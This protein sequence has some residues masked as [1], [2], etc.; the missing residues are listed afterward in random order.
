MSV[1]Y[2]GLSS[3]EA[4]YFDGK[5]LKQEVLSRNMRGP[6]F[7]SKVLDLQSGGDVK[8]AARQRAYTEAFQ[9]SLRPYADRAR[10]QGLG[11]GTVLCMGSLRTSK[12]DW[13]GPWTV[14]LHK[15]PLPLPSL[16]VRNVRVG[17]DYE[18]RFS[19]TTVGAGGFS[20]EAQ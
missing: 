3:A 20:T 12:T 6:D 15:Q 9:K 18:V 5:L 2:P 17:S 10:F 19:F 11:C 7:G 1:P 16:A 4:Q 8:A 14:D 13:V